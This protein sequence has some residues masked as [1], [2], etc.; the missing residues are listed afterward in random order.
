MKQKH[1][2]CEAPCYVIPSLEKGLRSRHYHKSG[3]LGLPSRVPP[4]RFRGTPPCQR[5]LQGRVRSAVSGTASSGAVTGKREPRLLRAG[6]FRRDPRRP[7]GQTW[8]PGVRGPAL[9]A[10]GRLA[11]PPGPPRLPPTAAAP[12]GCRRTFRGPQSTP[13]PPA[14]PIPDSKRG[15]RSQSGTPRRG[16]TG[17]PRQLRLRSREGG[18][19]EERSCLDG[20]RTCRPPILGNWRD[21]HRGGALGEAGHR[22]PVPRWWSG[23][24]RGPSLCTRTVGPPPNF[25]RP[26]RPAVAGGTRAQPEGAV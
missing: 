18:R 23:R 5:A 13:P 11:P 16:E 9:P 1:V 8:P 20:C 17:S 25:S 19:P 15:Q 3:R 26:R 12:E 22:Q 21:T 6:G 2:P 4:L 7:P 10:V 24:R 14:F